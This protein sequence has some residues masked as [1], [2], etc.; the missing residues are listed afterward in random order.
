[1]DKLRS[2]AIATIGAVG[3]T[4]IGAMALSH[5]V[6]LGPWGVI[7]TGAAGIIMWHCEDALADGVKS[8]IMHDE[9]RAAERFVEHIMPEPEVPHEDQRVL[10][11]LKR[12]VGI[13]GSPQPSSEYRYDEQEHGIVE[14]S[15]TMPALPKQSLALTPQQRLAEA[16]RSI[17]P[18]ARPSG[19]FP[20][21]PEDETLR[22][23]V[24]T[25]KK[26]RFDPWIN[27]LFGKGM[28]ASAVQGSGKSMLCGL[29][30]EQ[31]AK[32]GV[33]II[34][35]DHK[36]E[37]AGIVDLPFVNGLRAGSDALRSRTDCFELSPDNTDDFVQ[38]VM[39]E[40]HQAIVHLPSYGDG[41]VDRAEIVAS[42]GQS[43]MSYSSAQREAGQIIIPCL[44]FV[45][46]AQLYIP[47]NPNLL[48]PE[49]QSN[50]DILNSLNNAY[51]A[52]VSNGRSNGY[53][54]CFAT[55]SLTYIAKW[56]IKSCQ[57]R[58]LMRHTEKND[59]DMCEQIINPSVATR[60][61]MESMPKGTGVIF[62]F[63]DKPMVVHFD[64]KQS[65]DVSETP[66]IERLKA[67]Q[68][69]QQSRRLPQTSITTIPVSKIQQQE[70]LA[71]KKEQSKTT[72][73]LD[74]V[75]ALAG[76]V[77][78]ETLLALID[79]L[80]DRNGKDIDTEELAAFDEEQDDERE[81][82]P[83]LLERGLNAY[84]EGH[85]TIDSLAVVL[86]IS[87]WEARKL[88]PQ[89]KLALKQEQEN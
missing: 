27:D 74:T 62:G 29:L 69:V 5:S 65:R 57:I 66:G 42:V 48:P 15:N 3:V 78:D 28:I 20:Q 43:L 24:E 53:T 2:R 80:P 9:V 72:L 85:T 54:V 23:G 68:Q 6:T 71:V 8:M 32:C 45:D 84:S 38:L 11:K 18:P 12:L 41:W 61:E 58:V 33:P 30:I 55:Q 16:R 77:S 13:D 26:H 70:P 47:Q 17:I 49:A 50:K 63:T 21:Y 35:F 40:R 56:A 73:D 60:E 76:K 7:A 88:M 22:L 46:E 59:L 14:Q 86:S 10:S 83:T 79:R 67:P 75:L 19:V 37:Y 64:K 82:E 87:S 25:K 4:G 51:F 31:A 81:P 52:L 1:M 34:I 44:I 89:I 39:Q 36:G